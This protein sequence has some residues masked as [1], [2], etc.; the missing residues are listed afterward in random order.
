MTLPRLSLCTA[1]VLLA[2]SSLN[3]QSVTTLP[4]GAVNLEVKRNSDTIVAIPLQESATFKGT[5]ASATSDSI[6]VNGTPN[7]TTNQFQGFY[8]VRVLTG[9][10]AGMFYTV[11]ANA[12]SQVTLNTAG[13][14]IATLAAGD[15]IAI[16][17]HWTL[18]TLLP[19][20]TTPLTVSGGTGVAAR[21]S[22]VIIPDNTFNGVN[23]PAQSSYYFTSTGWKKAISGNPDAND[24]ILYPDEYIIIRQP[25]TVVSD[26]GLTLIG[27]VNK[28]PFA[29]TLSTKVGASRD[30]A[31]ALQRPTDIKLSESGLDVG[32]VSSLG[33][34][35]AQRRDLLLVFDNSVAGFNKAAARTY[36]RFGGNWIQAIA[37]NPVKNDDI[38]PAGAGFVIRKYQ[39]ASASV[40]VAVNT[41]N[42]S[43]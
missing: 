37:G 28:D 15:E 34:G 32:F 22:L 40:D 41:P 38:L 35:V 2:L 25:A 9:S 20:T 24:T 10:K 7:W 5:I 16:Y 11:T 8:F 13:D 36:Y 19:Y 26:V 14:S 43:L 3:A 17:K 21:R 30:N 6:T 33:T 29:V 31:V 4:V 27:S 1:T 12:A 42:F 23:L 39:N 18:N